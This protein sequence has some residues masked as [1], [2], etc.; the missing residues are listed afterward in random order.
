ML[1]KQK[2][3]KTTLK[4]IEACVNFW[5]QQ[6]QLPIIQHNTH[7]HLIAATVN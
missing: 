5:F 7:Q 4:Y 2:V 1:E 3:K 6:M